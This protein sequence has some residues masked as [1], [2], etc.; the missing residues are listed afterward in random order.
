[1]L[2]FVY[3]SVMDD[4]TLSGHKGPSNDD[5]KSRVLNVAVEVKSGCR[6]TLEWD[7]VFARYVISLNKFNIEDQLCFAAKGNAVHIQR[8]QGGINVLVK[9]TE[10]SDLNR[11]IKSSESVTFFLGYFT[12]E[13]ESSFLLFYNRQ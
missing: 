13:I 9:Y 6:L 8:L 10:E 5:M 2:F 12:S 11:W 4:F 1:M 3:S 7:E